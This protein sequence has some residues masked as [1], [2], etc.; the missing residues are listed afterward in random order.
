MTLPPG[1]LKFK[2]RVINCVFYYSIQLNC[3]T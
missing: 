2:T 3:Q 1:H